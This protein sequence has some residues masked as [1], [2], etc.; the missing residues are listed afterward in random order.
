MK[1][2]RSSAAGCLLPASKARSSPAARLRGL[3]GWPVTFRMP[4]PPRS[5]PSATPPHLIPT[6]ARV[7]DRY[8]ELRQTAGH[9]FDALGPLQYWT[10]IVASGI[11]PGQVKLV[12]IGGGAIAA[13]EYRMALALGAQVAIVEGS[14][15]SADRGAERWRVEH[16]GQPG[17]AA[18]RRRGVTDLP[19]VGG[20]ARDFT[21]PAQRRSHRWRRLPGRKP[22]VRAPSRPQSP[23]TAGK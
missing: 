6:H 21:D 3:P 20:E 5:T 1:G 2:Y 13:V 22:V 18:G 12:G 15:R 16:I 11:E 9:D 8:R 19:D 23:A 4:I 14:G 7:D 17:A 10:D